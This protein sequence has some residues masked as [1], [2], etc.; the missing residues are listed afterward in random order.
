MSSLSSGVPPITQ[1]KNH[2]SNIDPEVESPWEAYEIIVPA[3]TAEMLFTVTLTG[4]FNPVIQ[5]YH[6]TTNLWEII[7]K[8]QSNTQGPESTITFTMNRYKGYPTLNT[9]MRLYKAAVELERLLLVDILPNATGPFSIQVKAMERATF[10]THYRHTEADSDLEYTREWLNEETAGRVYDWITTIVPTYTHAWMSDKTVRELEA[11][12]H[13]H[14]V[15]QTGEHALTSSNLNV[16]IVIFTRTEARSVAVVNKTKLLHIESVETRRRPCKMQTHEAFIN[17][18]RILQS[19]ELID[20]QFLGLAQQVLVRKSLL[21]TITISD[22]L[23]NKGRVVCAFPSFDKFPGLQSEGSGQNAVSALHCNPDPP[24]AT[25]TSFGTFGVTHCSGEG[26]VKFRVDFCRPSHTVFRKRQHTACLPPYQQ[27]P[28]DEKCCEIIVD[29]D[30]S[31]YKQFVNEMRIFGNRTREHLGNPSTL[32]QDTYDWFVGEFGISG[33]IELW[34]LGST[35]SAREVF[36]SYLPNCPKLSIGIQRKNVDEVISL[37]TLANEHGL[38]YDVKYN[39]NTRPTPEDLVRLLSIRPPNETTLS[40]PI[41]GDPPITTIWKLEQ[42]IQ[43]LEHERISVIFA[44]MQETDPDDPT[45][46]TYLPYSIHSKV[47]GHMVY[48][49]FKIVSTTHQ[50]LVQM[51][52][53]HVNLSVETNNNVDYDHVS[54]LTMRFTAGAK[55]KPAPVQKSQGKKGKRKLAFDSDGSGNKI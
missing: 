42:W 48:R 53:N 7:S 55:Y 39:I 12:D 36:E 46:Y 6:A 21:D 30:S 18:A 28:D 54:K 52:K 43:T 17:P 15:E 32:I 51:R 1:S 44:Q 50:P 23:Q 47:V 29:N 40:F 13:T 11:Y 34:T 5:T 19:T 22:A 4:D 26:L 45:N 35:D 41:I 27:H 20:L 14:G 24:G 25:P 2:R 3:T 31:E 16:L 33:E 10:D 38:L 49:N 8:H 9:R 37:V